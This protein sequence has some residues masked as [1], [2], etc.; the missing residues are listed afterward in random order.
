MTTNELFDQDR[1]KGAFNSAR[2]EE[3]NE[4][5][6][7]QGLKQS[8]VKCVHSQSQGNF[9]RKYFAVQLSSKAVLKL[10]K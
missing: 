9:N 7:S 10:A 3:L 2:I 6:R 4:F 1:P 8:Q 5:Y